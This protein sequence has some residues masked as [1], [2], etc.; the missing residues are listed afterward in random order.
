MNARLLIN[1]AHIWHILLQ[2]EQKLP[3]K[4]AQGQEQGRSRKVQIQQ[5]RKMCKL[6]ANLPLT[7]GQQAERGSVL[8]KR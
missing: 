4:I 1:N 2:T 8:R 3:T 7:S 6:S 5:R